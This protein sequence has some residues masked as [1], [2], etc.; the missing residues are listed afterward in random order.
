[1]KPR[2]S[3]RR[4][5]DGSIFVLMLLAAVAVWRTTSVNRE[6]QATL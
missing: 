2:T 4:V 3:G 6:Y 1:M 5:L